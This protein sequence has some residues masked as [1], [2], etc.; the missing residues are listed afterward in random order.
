MT[1]SDRT[2]L[3]AVLD[4]AQPDLKPGSSNLELKPGSQA[5]LY[6]GSPVVNLGERGLFAK[7][8]RRWANTRPSSVLVLVFVSVPDLLEQLHRISLCLEGDKRLVPF[9]G[10]MSTY[11]INPWDPTYLLGHNIIIIWGPWHL[12]SLLGI[13][14]LVAASPFPNPKFL[15]TVFEHFNII[16]EIFS[17]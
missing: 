5:N 16:F 13:T 11:K 4:P 7:N 17:W 6:W 8:P 14:R 15:E 12:I 1:K 10:Q 3:G 9:R 2:S